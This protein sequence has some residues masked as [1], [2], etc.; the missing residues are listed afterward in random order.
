MLEQMSARRP[1]YIARLLTIFV[2]LVLVIGLTAT[3]VPAQELPP[4]Q[5]EPTDAELGEK[6]EPI[7][8]KETRRGDVKT[9][10]LEIPVGADTFT[11]SGLPNTNWS[12]NPNLR[13]G[14]NQTLGHGAQ[15][16]YLFFD[17][18]SIPGNATVQS[19]LLRAFV[20]GFSPNG[21]APMGLLARFL[22]TPWDASLLTWNNYQPSWGLEIGV[23]QIAATTGW[24]EAP[25]TSAVG[26]WVAGTRPNNGILIQGDETPQQRERVFTAL[27]AN[28]GLHPRLV[29]TYDVIVDTT[30]PTSSVNQLATWSPGTFNVSWSGTDNPGGSGIK[31]YDVQF[32]ANN[33]VWQNW[34][35]AT[36]TTSASF[37]GQNGTRYDFRVR[38]VDKQNNVEA[39]P[40]NPD[41]GTTVDTMPPSATVNPLPQYTFANTFNVT[42]VGTDTGSGPSGGS[43]IAHF[44]VEFQLNGGPWTPFAT[45]TTTTSGTVL[46]ALSGQVYAFRARA[47]DKVGNVQPLPANPQAQT[48]VSLGNPVA[49]IMP[50]NVP[51]STV[52]NF[53]V[54]WTGQAP[55][56][57]TIVAYDVQ[58]RFN[59]GAWQNWLTNVNVTSQ[60]FSAISG[61]GVYE[62]QVRARDSIGRVSPFNG[63]PASSI[64]VDVVAPKITVRIYNPVA[65]DN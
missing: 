37:T 11:T 28:N 31:N 22:S 18:S 34:L 17:V 15:R 29:V 53:L 32:R 52:N 56:G 38:A 20:N 61:D 10:T 3:V 40:A 16:V 13:V 55:P 62:F 2:F 33:G 8:L 41:T 27:N 30:P 43:G 36:T 42:W 54:Q 14:F 57:A 7:I 46:N 4:G 35:T 58:F 59:G 60:Q 48:T 19:A 47:V 44:D 50:F 9:I 64:A 39:W 65:A 25:L 63:G 23:G 24:I 12:T 49:S 26:E 5:N 1:G 51:I 45:M 21:D 6:L